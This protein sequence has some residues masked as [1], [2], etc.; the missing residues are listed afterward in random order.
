MRISFLG[1]WRV[2]NCLQPK[3]RIFLESEASRILLTSP[4]GAETFFILGK[5]RG[6]RFPVNGYTQALSTGWMLHC[7]AVIAGSILLTISP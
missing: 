2:L 5:F 7:L 1:T 3:S 4:F 6:L